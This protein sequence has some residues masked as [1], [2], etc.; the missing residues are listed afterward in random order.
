MSKI[1]KYI[2]QKLLN[3]F[4]SNCQIYLSQIENYLKTNWGLSCNSGIGLLHIYYNFHEIF[5]TNCKM[6]LSQIV[7]SIC[8]KVEIS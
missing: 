1:A 5:V 7:K 4:V 6:Y 8:L 3:V 2:C